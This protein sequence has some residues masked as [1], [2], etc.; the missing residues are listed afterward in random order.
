MK[1]I[2]KRLSL[3]TVSI[4]LICWL[5]NLIARASLMR[6]VAASGAELIISR[7]HGLNK[8]TVAVRDI[9]SDLKARLES[10]V[11]RTASHSWLDITSWALDVVAKGHGFSVNMLP[12][13][14][15]FYCRYNDWTMQLACRNT[16]E[17]RELVFEL[18]EW[19]NDRMEPVYPCPESTP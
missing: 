1:V 18:R 9:P 2:L 16:Q 13:V 19:L 7:N 14:T 10:L 3:F 15:V 12:N 17:E 5:A 11:E 8:A 4:A 6:T